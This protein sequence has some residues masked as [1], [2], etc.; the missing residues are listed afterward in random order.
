M[1]IVPESIEVIEILKVLVVPALA[2]LH[3]LFIKQ[4]KEI[5]KLKANA[6]TRS[7]TCADRLRWISKIDRRGQDNETNNA[8]LTS[9]MDTH[10]DLKH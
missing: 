10:E 8:V 6:E 5:A 1:A 2:I 9:R 4:G 3:G 7:G